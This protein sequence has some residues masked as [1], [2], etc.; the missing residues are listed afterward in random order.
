MNRFS[1]LMFITLLSTLFLTV[2]AQDLTG[3]LKEAESF[4]KLLKE[5]EALEKYKQVL[6]IAPFNIKALGKAAELNVL[7]GGN[8]KDKNNK[9][10]YFETAKSFADKAI[11]ADAN[12]ADANYLI[13]MVSGKLTD[14]ES[15][16]KK[17]VN[18][19]K[20]VKVYADKA[21]II[22]P[23][24]ARANYTLGKWHLE[25]VSL[26][27]FKKVAVKLLYGGL[28]DGDLNKAILYMEK[29]KS[30]EPYFA[31]AYLDLGKAYIANN[32]NQS[33]IETLNKLTKLPNRNTE[34]IAI[35]EEGAKLLST[36]N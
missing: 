14:I 23:N 9:R 3:L 5:P 18:L 26:S 29:S 32:Q 31:P 2:S 1:Q 30:L 35:K 22:N 20:D 19:V 11:Q 6:S 24:H 34:Y 21:L 15:D 28:P 12:N 36:L 27:G 25:M 17:I 16:N 8:Q 13:S 33:A 10:L 7:L 4:E